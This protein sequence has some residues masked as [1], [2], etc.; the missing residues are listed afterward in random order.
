MW[1]IVYIVWGVGI[2]KYINYVFY[3]KGRAFCVIWFRKQVGYKKDNIWY[4]IAYVELFVC[5][6]SFKPICLEYFNHYYP[7][8]VFLY[9]RCVFKFVIQFELITHVS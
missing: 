1:L 9:A 5:L 8:T 2:I 4:K 6:L 7:A 3:V